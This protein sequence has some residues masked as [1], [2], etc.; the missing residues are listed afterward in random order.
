MKC[1]LDLLVVGKK[2]DLCSPALPM[3]ATPCTPDFLS[4]PYILQL[5]DSVSVFLTASVTYYNHT[6]TQF[7]TL[8]SETWDE[9]NKHNTNIS[10]LDYILKRRF[11]PV[12]RSSTKIGIECFYWWLHSTDA[13]VTLAGVTHNLLLPEPEPGPVSLLRLQLGCGPGCESR[14]R[15]SS[16]P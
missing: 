4:Q 15:S 11:S 6:L 13:D 1:H 5:A 7:V 9:I 3:S 12:Q 16:S 8:S 2:T 14:H 10:N